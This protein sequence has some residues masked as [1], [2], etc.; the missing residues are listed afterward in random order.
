MNISE[1]LR[2]KWSMVLTNECTT[3][4]ESKE[5]PIDSFK[6]K[7]SKAEQFDRMLKLDTII[8]NDPVALTVS[9]TTSRFKPSSD[10]NEVAHAFS[11]EC[12]DDCPE[13]M[14]TA[15]VDPIAQIMLESDWK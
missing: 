6:E 2:K 5:T 13:C 11:P 4:L 8:D 15:Y 12:G 14:K 9:E 3:G 1:E 10:N 7:E